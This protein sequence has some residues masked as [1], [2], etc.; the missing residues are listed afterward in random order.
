MYICFRIYDAA[1]E[2]LNIEIPSY[3]GNE[4]KIKNEVQVSYYVNMCA[5]S[6]ETS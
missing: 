2:T 6:H 3:Y 1:G 4:R 5:K